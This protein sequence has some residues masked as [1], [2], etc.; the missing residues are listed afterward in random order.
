MVID[1]TIIGEEQV[2]GGTLKFSARDPVT[3]QRFE[4]FIPTEV[5]EAP[6]PLETQQQGAEVGIITSDDA[7]DETKENQLTLGEMLRQAS[8]LSARLRATTD[9]EERD[10]ISREGVRGREAGEGLTREELAEVGGGEVS[11]DERLLSEQIAETDTQLDNASASLDSIRVRLNASSQALVES[12]QRDFA[13]RRKQLADVNK[14]SLAS[15]R[16]F[17]I[18]R[19]GQRFA[20]EITTG[21]LSAEERAGITRLAELDADEASLIAKAELA[22]T[23]LDFELLSRQINLIRQNR[24]NK[25]RELEKLQKASFEKN[26][27]TQERLESLIKESSILNVI[28]GGISD[29]ADIFNQLQGEA[30]LDEINDVLDNTLREEDEDFGTGAFGLFNRLK[31]AGEIPEDLGFFEFQA[32]DAASKRKPGDGKI[33]REDLTAFERLSAANLSVKIFGKRAGTKPE[34]RA[35]IEDLMAGGMSIDDIG[36]QLRF[37]GQSSDFAGVVR[38]AAESIGTAITSENRRNFFFDSIDRSLEDGDM[39]RVKERLFSEAVNTLGTGEASRV[40]GEQRAIE[41]FDEIGVDLKEF[42]KKG[43]K[44][45]IFSGKTEGLLERVGRTKDPELA[46]IAN[47]IAIGIQ[48]YRRSISGAAFTESEAKEYKAVFASIDNVSEL[49]TAKLESAREVLSGDVSF[50]LSE[51]IG[52]RA[53]EE[54]FGKDFNV[55]QEEAEEEQVTTSQEVKDYL[56]SFGLE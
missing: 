24:D 29:P 48:R 56:D 19:G 28:Q 26:K 50:V 47:K 36:D 53:Y 5:A 11:E 37:T 40:R 55:V 27:E 31:A 32:L 20:P 3:G 46:K 21:I 17:A 23:A 38:D 7:R 22:N 34:N 14:R 35:L 49:N 33:T 18:R 9:Q 52:S 2:E 30:T 13:Q 45:G 16:Q 12:I 51:R 25:Q 15:L 39:E 43:G 41:L 44:T 8:D 10:R 6:P 54:I 4:T 1:R 42:E